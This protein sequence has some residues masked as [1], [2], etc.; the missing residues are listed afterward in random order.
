MHSSQE[1]PIKS[2]D[3]FRCFPKIEKKK[4]PPTQ[5]KNM[6]ASVRLSGESMAKHFCGGV[7]RQMY[8]MLKL[9]KMEDPCIF[10]PGSL[11]ERLSLK[12]E[13]FTKAK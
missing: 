9:S 4:S 6:L 13:K 1:H 12:R 11:Q 8:E 10:I 5:T 3:W 2:L 7:P